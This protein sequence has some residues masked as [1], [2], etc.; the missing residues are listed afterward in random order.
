MTVAEHINEHTRCTEEP[1][2]EPDAMKII[3]TSFHWSGQV[4]I[5]RISKKS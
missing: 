4:D 2:T 3:M 1:R 5:A